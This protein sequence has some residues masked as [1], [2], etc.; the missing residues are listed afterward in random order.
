MAK[1]PS[2]QYGGLD[3]EVLIGAARIF[4]NSPCVARNS[5]VEWIDCRPQH[6]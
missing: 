6:S 1:K 3:R 2:M 4:T 5:M